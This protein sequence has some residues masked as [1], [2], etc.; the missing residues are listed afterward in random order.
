MD[1]INNQN[2]ISLNVSR[3]LSYLMDMVNQ[4]DLNNKLISKLSLIQ[5]G[6]WDVVVVG[7]GGWEGLAA[8][9]IHRGEG[10]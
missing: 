5:N 6:G 4:V 7:S 8:H 2:H 3:A 10:T 1:F 9:L